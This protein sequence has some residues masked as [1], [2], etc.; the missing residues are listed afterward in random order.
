MALGTYVSIIILNVSGLNS[1]TKRH[2]LAEWIQRQDPYIYYLQETQFRPKDTYRLK[3]RRW[4]NIFHTNVKQKKP[5][6]AILIS[7]K[8]DLK[9]KKITL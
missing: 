4:K 8:I 2:I 7:D 1:P 5:G 3:V 6:V 9:V